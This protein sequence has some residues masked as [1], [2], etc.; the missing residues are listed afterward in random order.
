MAGIAG[1]IENL[2]PV[3][4]PES[5]GFRFLMAAEAA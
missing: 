3:H 4:V 5:E 1:D 2:M